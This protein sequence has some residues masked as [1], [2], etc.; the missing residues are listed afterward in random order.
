MN[1]HVTIRDGFIRADTIRKD[2][3]NGL[4][5]YHYTANAF[6]TDVAR[7]SAALDRVMFDNSDTEITFTTDSKYQ[8]ALDTVL[9]AIKNGKVLVSL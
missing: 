1:I 9:D 8:P 5:H 3:T 4:N 7:F 6:Q 2:G